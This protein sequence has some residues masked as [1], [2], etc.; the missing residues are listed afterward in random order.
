MFF[1]GQQKVKKIIYFNTAK[2]SFFLMAVITV[3]K[4]SNSKYDVNCAVCLDIRAV[5]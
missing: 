2:F 5:E 4:Q 3:S 1:K